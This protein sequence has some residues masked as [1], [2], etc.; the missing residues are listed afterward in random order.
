MNGSEP[1]GEPTEKAMTP[2]EKADAV[3][4][5][6]QAQLGDKVQNVGPPIGHH[7]EPLYTIVVK[8]TVSR[9]DLEPAGLTHV[10]FK[11]SLGDSA[12]LVPETTIDR[13]LLVNGAL[14]KKAVQ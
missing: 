10:D 13:I 4:G 3:K 1:A 14:K 9:D 5:I 2:K 7:S 8:P 11:K 12:W 6:L